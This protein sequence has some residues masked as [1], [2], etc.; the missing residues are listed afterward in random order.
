[1]YIQKADLVFFFCNLHLIS[2]VGLEGKGREGLSRHQGRKIHEILFLKLIVCVWMFLSVSET[3]SS[4][5]VGFVTECTMVQSIWLCS[6]LIISSL[7]EPTFNL[8]STELYV[9]CEIIVLLKCEIWFRF[10]D[11]FQHRKLLLTQHLSSASVPPR[12]SSDL[13]LRGGC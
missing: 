1:M 6:F 12:V 11:R 8:L 13:N 5:L 4:G 3:G 10:V 7:S 9:R 2:D